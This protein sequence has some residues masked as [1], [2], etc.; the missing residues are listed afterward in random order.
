MAKIL[1]V[2]DE[3]RFR[4][5]L[6]ERLRL[7]GYETVSAE[8][9]EDAIKA[10]RTDRDIDVVLLDRKMPGMSGEQTLKEIKEFRPELPVVMLTGHGDIHSAREAGRLDAYRYLNKPVEL[11]A[12][13]EILEEAREEKGYAAQR[14][15]VPMVQGRTVWAWLL[16]THNSRPLFILLGL[17]LFTGIAMMP[18]PDR[19]VTLLG[20][21]KAA[22]GESVADD[23]SIQGY[24]DYRKMA[25]GTTVAQ[26]Y[27]TK[28]DMLR[29]TVAEDGSTTKTPLKPEQAGR[30]A[31][32]MLAV[33]VLAA[34]FWASGAAPVGVTAL[35]VGAVMYLFDVLPPDG[36]AQAFAKD[37]VIFI[38]GV[39][40]LSRA[41]TKTGLDRRI[42]LLLLAPAKN[43]TL[44]LLVFLPL[45]SITCSFVSEHALV[46]FTMPLFV[47][48]YASTMQTLGIKQDRALM[49]MFALSLCYAANSGGP[50]SPAA[51]GRNAIMVGILADYGIAPSFGE[52]VMYGLPLVPVMSFCVGLY[53]LLVLRPKVKVKSLDATTIVRRASEKIG[54]MTR[55]EYVTLA[56]LIGVIVLW[57]TCST[58]LGMGGPVILGLVILN[59][60][61]VAS[62]KDI[63]GIHWEVVFLYASASAIGKGLAVTGGALFLADGF[64][65]VLPDFMREGVGL[66]IASSFFTGTVTNFMSDG[67]TV[68]AI[69]P[70]TVPMATIANVHPWMI[71]LATAFASSFAHML[72]I[73][74]P[75]NALAFALAKDPVTGEQLVTLGDF[76]KHGFFVVMISFAVLWGWA[77]FGYWRWIG[78]P[79][80]G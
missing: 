49:V 57:I 20:T 47:M 45:L 28:N 67:A 39:L 43:L 63:A 61:R 78:F 53:F 21:P 35:I 24:A 4:Q 77:F 73:G 22:A 13:V 42:G 9:G 10:V 41:I 12:L 34:L 76:M 59:I 62:W 37:A 51:G 64:V 74:T 54:P 40:A 1:L 31:F 48:I 58:S 44:L 18:I 68:A 33:I 71:G 6:A 11:D 32:V 30:R 65:A 69:G 50:G 14:H 75:S 15:E 27:S 19:M 70:I 25:E 26:H 7:R 80:V 52:W 16:G 8:C 36:I 3:H 72:I 46:A 66:A 5:L 23:A 2:D 29:K 55:E 79:P 38:F 17:A 56:V 60:L